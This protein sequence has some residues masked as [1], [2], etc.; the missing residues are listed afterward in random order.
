MPSLMVC[1]QDACWVPADLSALAGLL[2]DLGLTGDTCTDGGKNTFWPGQRFLNLIMFL[3]CSP[4]VSLAP[5][6]DGEGQ[7][8]CR[9]LL[10]RYSDVQCLSSLH[11]PDVRCPHCKIAAKVNEDIAHNT[12]YLCAGCGVSVPVSDLDWRR[13]AGFGRFFLEVTGIFPHEAVPSD[14][15]LDTLRR[16]AGVPWRY[17]YC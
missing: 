13:A 6:Q 16:Y 12:Q 1:P 11:R 10:R 4:R 17:F 8:V 15:L 2:G 5:Q 3:G 9:L 7:P 14:K